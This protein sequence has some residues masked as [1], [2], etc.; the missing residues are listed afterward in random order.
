M[1]ASRHHRER[2]IGDA[3]SRTI[4]GLVA[5]WLALTPALTGAQEQRAT[6]AAEPMMA[7][8]MFRG[9]AA[10]T[11]EQPGPGPEGDPVLLWQFDTDGRVDS[12]PAVV[13]GVVYVGSSDGALY[14]VGSD[15]S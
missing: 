2:F 11:G 12:T 4:V 7:A 6:P 8:A 3:A 13:D 15:N 14:A 1:H 10:G 5:L 9:N